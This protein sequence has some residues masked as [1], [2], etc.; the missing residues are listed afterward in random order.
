MS[1][2]K[3]GRAGE[4]EIVD[5]YNFHTLATVCLLIAPHNRPDFVVNSSPFSPSFLFI[6]STSPHQEQRQ[7]VVVH[8]SFSC[9]AATHS[10][11]VL[12]PPSSAPFPHPFLILLTAICYVCANVFLLYLSPKV[13]THFLHAPVR[14]LTN[15][16]SCS[17]AEYLL[18]HFFYSMSCWPSLILK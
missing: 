2:I 1:V 11:L 18:V 7:A 12:F 15:T 4:E 5:L 14:L 17:P 3:E 6:T 9:Q 10:K 8:H 16:T 13:P